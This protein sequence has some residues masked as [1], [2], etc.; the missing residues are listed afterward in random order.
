[1]AEC[2]GLGLFQVGK[3]RHR[4]GPFDNWAV[5]RHSQMARIA[6]HACN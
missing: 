4:K 3:N 6:Y 5:V 1:M 2:L